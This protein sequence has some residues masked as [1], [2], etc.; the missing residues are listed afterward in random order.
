MSR[1]GSTADDGGLPR[2]EYKSLPK[3]KSIRY[4]VLDPG[5][6]DEP[7]SGSLTVE[8]IDKVPDFDAISYVWGPH[9]FVGQITC[10]GRI[11]HLTASLRDAL[12][13][14]RLPNTARNIW[15]DQIS[16]NQQDLAE[17][18]H[19]VAL[20]GKIYRKSQ[21]TLIWLGDAADD[22]VEEVRAL[23]TDV[24]DLVRAQLS[25]SNGSWDDMPVVSS[26]DTISCDQR[27]A[28]LAKMTD[29]PWFRRVWVVPEAGLSARPQILYGKRGIDWESFITV[30]NWLRHRGTHIAYQF[31]IEWHAIHMDRRQVWTHANSHQVQEESAVNGNCHPPGYPWS[32][33]DVLSA[34]RQLEAS[35]PKDHIYAFLGHP[36][37]S[38]ADTGELI[39]DPDYTIDTM[40]TYSKFAIGWLRWTQDLN[41]L[42]FVQH[43]DAGIPDTPVPSWVPMW[44]EYDTSVLAQNGESIFSAGM[45]NKTAP[46]LFNHGKCLKVGGVTFDKILFR[47][48]AFNE[49]DFDWGNKRDAEDR[50]TKGASKW[51]AIL[52]HVLDPFSA[53]IYADDQ[54]FMACAATLAAGMYSGSL[55]EFESRAAAFLSPFLVSIAPYIGHSRAQAHHDKAASSDTQLCEAEMA[56]PLINRRFIVTQ[57]GYYGLAPITAR[58]GDTCCIIF[59]ARTPFIVRPVAHLLRQY[60]LIG[61]AYVHGIMK[62]EIVERRANGEF[63]E[64]AIILV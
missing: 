31:H 3:N 61:E 22:Q 50:N 56:S 33:L 43:K 17:R 23:I 32:L 42:S 21:T 37:A 30:L 59:G 1:V 58:A 5:K 49:K 4:L 63:Q 6:D 10:D 38:Q 62:G 34:S 47:S 27:W 52:S 26:T 14:V 60:K 12:R 35:E 53:C 48:S 29:C 40:Q 8:H 24:N 39:V 16:I 18:S 55:A 15:A 25:E 46:Q 20:M 28:S 45:S 54:R 36:S 51:A 44:N 11:I 19:Q 64:D 7:L 2:Y 57:S 13:R 41:I 9:H